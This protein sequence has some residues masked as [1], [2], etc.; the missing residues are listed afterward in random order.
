MS[1]N[2]GIEWA[3]GSWNAVTGC[4]GKSEGCMHCYARSMALRLQG[5]GKEKYA[6]G[7]KPTVHESE[8]E[9]PLKWKK[10]KRIFAVSMGDLFNP[11]VPLDFIKRV[12]DTI[13]RADWHTFVILTK[14]PERAL[15]FAG[16]LTWPKNLWMGATIESNRHVERADYLRSIPATVRVL[17][18]EPLLGPVPDLDLTGINW[19]IVGG[20]SG[21]SARPMEPEWVHDIRDRCIAGDVAFFFKQ[22]GGRSRTKAGHEIDG[23]IWHEYP[24]GV[25]TSG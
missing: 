16:R 3:E 2:T 12:F 4:T 6:A 21:S 22:W 5:M 18:L 9:T 14:W 20:E 23:Q 1:V 19:V 25:R 13:T 11:E 8:L 17:S 10:P 24:A 15:E 7:F